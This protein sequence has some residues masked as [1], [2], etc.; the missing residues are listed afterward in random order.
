MSGLKIQN[1]VV[2]IAIRQSSCKEID[3]NT[4]VFQNKS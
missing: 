1:R 2:T 3:P 4:V